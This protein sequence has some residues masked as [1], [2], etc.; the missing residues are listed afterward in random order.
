[1][2][3][4]IQDSAKVII[5]SMVVLFSVHLA[6]AVWS[7]PTVAPTGGNI[8]APL[9]VSSTGQTKAGGLILNTGGSTNGLVVSAGKVG[10]GVADPAS[11][12]EVYGGS[13]ASSQSTG[14]IFRL[15][16]SGLGRLLF[17]FDP[18][19]PFGSWIQSNLSYPILL[20]PVAGNV[21]IGT[22]SPSQ[23][24]SV[25]GT[26]YSSTGGFKFPDGTTQTTAAGGAALE[27][28][29]GLYTKRDTVCTNAN[30][31]T[32]ACSCEAGFTD[33]TFLTFSVNASFSCGWYEGYTTTG[34]CGQ[35]SIETHECWNPDVIAVCGNNTV[36]GSE[37]CDG[38]D[39]NSQTCALQVGEG[40]SGTLSCNAGCTAF[41]TAACIVSPSSTQ[42]FSYTGSET[43]FVV[44][45]G[46]T[47]LTVDLRGPG[48]GGGG[49]A[50]ELGA[51][52]G[53][54]ATAGGGG[55]AA[56][57][58]SY[59]KRGGTTLVQAAI[60]AGGAGG[61]G[62]DQTC[63]GG[64]GGAA[65]SSSG[66]TL[67]AGAGG[68]GGAGGYS[69]EGSAHDNCGAGPTTGGTAGSAGDKETG[70]LAVTPG[71]TLTIRVGGGG[72]GGANTFGGNGNSTAGSAGSNGSLTLT[73]AYPNPYAISTAG[74]YSFIVPTGV[75]SLTIDV[76]GGGGG[77]A[78][79]GF[80]DE[81]VGCYPGSGGGGGSAGTGASSIGC[82]TTPYNGAA[83]SD[84][85]ISRGATVLARAA[86][87]KGGDVEGSWTG[88]STGTNV[89]AGLS[90][91]SAGGGA[92]GS[93]GGAGCGSFPGPTGLSGV[94]GDK[95]TGTIAVTPGETLSLIV[96][97]PGG[98]S[99]GGSCTDGADGGAA[100]I[101][102]SW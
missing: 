48:G 10:I 43:T 44:P 2:M 67:T 50:E 26:I 13:G 72:A 95:V 75:T 15:S 58:N 83:G 69:S 68:A 61:D 45:S 93:G 52:G 65:G 94:A 34:P 29:G 35:S 60:G 40:Y 82:G 86:T 90:L 25:A 97:T 79:S 73:W 63:A 18:I 22:T 39:L 57:T 92:A 3:K 88:G 1:M 36:E 14:D 38:S 28:F 102:I 24:L 101:S 19:T 91:T 99:G 84:S 55:A 27:A 32:D 7:E 59:I 9:D 62:F 30:P 100:S 4:I 12:L 56:G 31:L 41:V 47:S 20:N 96:G 80:D 77:G 74:T 64:A 81:V 87:G 71:E 46:V 6:G 8:S 54:G 42:T 33:T 16:S 17:G 37:V 85:R 49:G 53:G 66:L 21:G 70:D 51:G 76:R 89:Y 23:A 78:G 11:A 98:E 5:L